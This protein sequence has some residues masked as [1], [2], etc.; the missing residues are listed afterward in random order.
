[1]VFT[2]PGILGKLLEFKIFFQDP[3]KFLEKQKISL[4]SWKTP[5]IW[6]SPVIRSIKKLYSISHCYMDV[7][8]EEGRLIL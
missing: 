3:G 8:P 6:L 1:M 7:M 4:Y 2:T 5:G